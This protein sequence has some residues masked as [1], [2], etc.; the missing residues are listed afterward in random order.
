M[1]AAHAVSHVLVTIN[2]PDFRDY[3]GLRPENWV[4]PSP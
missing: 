1:I 4:A 2:K 3:P